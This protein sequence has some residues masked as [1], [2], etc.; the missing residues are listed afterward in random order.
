MS[1][2]KYY[3]NEETCKYEKVTVTPTESILN[4]IGYLMVTLVFAFGL[5]Y[6]YLKFFESPKEAKLKKENQELKFHYDK[7][8][9]NMSGVE[10]MLKSLESRDENIYRIIFEADPIPFSVRSAGAGGAKRYDG[11]EGKGLEEDKEEMIIDAYSKLDLLKRKMYIQTKSYD[12][13]TQLAEDKAKML[14][15]IPAIQPISNKELKR[16]ASGFGMRIHPIYK[17]KKF[18]PG[19]DFA[20]PKG[21]PIYA[22]GDGV[23]KKVQTKFGGYGKQIEID[24]GYGFVTKYAHLSKFNVKLGQKIKRGEIIGYV[25]TSGTSTAPHLHYEVI[26]NGEKVNPVYYFFNDLDPKEYEKILQLAFVENQSLS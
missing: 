4:I 18:H 1:R 23:I 8:S 19:V 16:L 22:T 10:D 13:I 26:K 17:V 12:E 5:L 9:K 20:A 2:I 24:H 14:A 7:L 6:G 21:T 15:S 11:V 25:G 3:Y